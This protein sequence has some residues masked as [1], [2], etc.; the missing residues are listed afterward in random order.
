M[1]F[2]LAQWEEMHTHI[3]RTNFA[4]VLGTTEVHW[5]LISLVLANQLSG[6][7]ISNTTIA[8]VWTDSAT[9]LPPAMQK[10]SLAWL[11]AL[12]YFLGTVVQ[13]FTTLMLVKAKLGMKNFFLIALPG[14]GPLA[15]WIFNVV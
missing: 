7:W 9:F 6:L 8:D 3:M 12:I 2:Y 5:I 10:R 14:L 15:L 11:F 13:L 1:V 4:G